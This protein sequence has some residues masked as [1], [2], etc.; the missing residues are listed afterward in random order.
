[1]IEFICFIVTVII[2]Y[3]IWRNSDE[4]LLDDDTYQVMIDTE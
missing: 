4:P 1:M 3:K 2:A